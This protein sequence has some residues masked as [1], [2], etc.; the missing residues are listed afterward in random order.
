MVARKLLR[1]QLM[2][3]GHDA[4]L[5]RVAELL[6]TAASGAPPF[7]SLLTPQAAA[8]SYGGPR[9]ARPPP[10]APGSFVNIGVTSSTGRPIALAPPPMSAGTSV[11][12]RGPSGV[13]AYH[14][15]DGMLGRATWSVGHFGEV[16][17]VKASEAYV[18]HMMD[19]EYALEDDPGLFLSQAGRGRC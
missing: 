19:Q 5:E 6:D 13:P 17:G 9:R 1:C 4:L 15:Q 8:G 12:T 11:A 2:E 3:R 7:C 18:P 10:G 14:P 16:F